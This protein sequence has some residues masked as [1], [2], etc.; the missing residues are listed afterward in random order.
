M[1]GGY[2]IFW[3]EHALSELEETLEYLVKNFLKK[4]LKNFPAK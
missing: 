3:T 2:K 1:K 4:N